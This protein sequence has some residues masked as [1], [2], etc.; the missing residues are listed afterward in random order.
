MKNRFILTLSV[1][2]F[3]FVATV[4]PVTANNNPT[5]NI[6][7]T[8]VEAGNF[9]IL[10]KALKATG[11]DETL[12]GG[13]FTVFAPT[14]DAFKKLPEGT[15]DNL[16]KDKEALKRILLYHVVE[17]KMMAKDVVSKSELKTVQG[18]NAKI[19]NKPE[20][21]KVKINKSKIIKTDIVAT[22]GVIHAIDT[23][24]MPN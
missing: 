9:T 23:V 16:L 2:A 1:I 11:L 24:L 8:A 13:N 15:L 6:V 10:K 20:K 12:K 4:I 5:K 3:L 14:D 7:E 22:N 17:G 21:N 19:Y 18:S